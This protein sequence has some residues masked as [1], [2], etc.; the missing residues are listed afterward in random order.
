MVDT[1]QIKEQLSCIQYCQ[2]HGIEGINAEGAR[3]VSPLRK[4]A[5]NA[6]SF[7][8][9]RDSWRDWGADMW[10]DVIDLCAYHRYDG[11]RGEAI[12]YLAKM[13]GVEDDGSNA[14]W[15]AY[16]QNLCNQ[17]AYWHEHLTDAARKYMHKRGITD[18]TIER[19]RIGTVTDGPLEGRL[20]IPY[21]KNG[22]VAYYCTR[23]MEGG[24]EPDKKYMKMKLDDYNDHCPW[25][26]HTLDRDPKRDTVVI[27]EGA[28]DIMS[29]E[30]ESAKGKNWACLSAITGSFSQRQLREIMPLLKAYKTVYIIYDNDGDGR[31]APGGAGEKFTQKMSRILFAANIPFRVCHCPRGYKDVSDYYA[32]GGDLQELLDNSVDGVIALAKTYGENQTRELADLCRSGCRFRSKSDVAMLFSELLRMEIWDRDFLM[33]LRSECMSAPTE[34]YVADKVL[35][36]HTL[37]YNDKIGMREYDGICWVDVSESRLHSYIDAELGVYATGSKLSSI[38]KVVKSRCST[39]ELFDQSPVMSFSNG[40]LELLPAIKFRSHSPDDRCTTSAPYPYDPAATC[41]QWEAFIESV[42]DGDAR[43]M[44]LLQEIA[45]YVLQPNNDMQSAMFLIGE[46]SNGKSVFTKILQT[47]FGS[48]R[49]TSIPIEQLHQ[50][51]QLVLTSSSV[52]NISSETSGEMTEA[53][54]IF[55]AAVSGDPLTACYKGRDYFSFRPRTKFFVNCNA[56]PKTTDLSDGFLRRCVFVQ[57]PIRF[58]KDREPRRP[59]ERKADLHL[60]EK[61]PAQ[62]ALPGIFNW[63]LAGYETIRATQYFTETDEQG[64]IKQRFKE[65]TNPLYV[66]AEDSIADLGDRFSGSELYEKYKVWCEITHHKTQASNTFIEKITPVLAEL[67]PDFE[68]YRTGKSHRN[69]RRKEYENVKMSGV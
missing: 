34:D 69:W 38:A 53:T 9:W 29:F 44:A 25:G 3:C 12:R 68:T 52:L 13:T 19:L 48:D 41:P 46:G 49:T 56:L 30:Q 10:G 63:I 11:D 32:D 33:A 1:K 45:G 54:S 14:D 65:A 21:Y 61:L 59:N 55:K 37:L 5:K 7:Q 24:A 51:F 22:Y 66:F 36:A 23:A 43:K 6:T 17:I 31:T 28:F 47:I 27:A 64:A 20:C 18:E 62:E 4:D 35:E 26:L 58:V 15:V 57:F 8:V 42:T 50:P 2:Q 39:A 40:T 67:Y 16:T 60:E